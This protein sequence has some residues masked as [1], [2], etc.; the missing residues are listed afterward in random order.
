MWE[1]AFLLWILKQGWSKVS[2]KCQQ[3]KG[4]LKSKDLTQLWA[5]DAVISPDVANQEEN[6]NNNKAT[7]QQGWRD[8][9]SNDLH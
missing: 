1:A 3:A 8:L 7:L 4:T 6:N 9:Q 2:P 5:Q